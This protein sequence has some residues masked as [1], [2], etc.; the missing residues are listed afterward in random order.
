MGIPVVHHPV[1]DHFESPTRWRSIRPPSNGLL[2]REIL[3]E[4]LGA[5]VPRCMSFKEAMAMQ[6][7]QR[8]GR[9]YHHCEGSREQGKESCLEAAAFTW[10]ESQRRPTDEQTWC[11]Y[12][13]RRQ[14][15]DGWLDAIP[16][17]SAVS[18]DL[19]RRR[20][21]GDVALHQGNVLLEG[22]Q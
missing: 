14:P 4:V 21:H 16:G 8:E 2:L 10:W 7:G 19:Q 1:R 20:A 22:L 15:N 6:A 11:T 12:V 17:D 18:Q 9:L 5:E 3:K 13:Q